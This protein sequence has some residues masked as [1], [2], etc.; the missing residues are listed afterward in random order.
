MKQTTKT[1]SILLILFGLIACGHHDHENDHEHEHA[2]D[3]HA[4]HEH[5]GSEILFTKEQQAKVDFATEQAK[6]TA[7]NQVIKTTAQILPAQTEERIL[8]AKTNGVVSFASQD[9]LSGKTV[10]KGQTLLYVNA[11][12][13]ADN[14]LAIRFAEAESQYIRTKADY[15][16]KQA[17]AEQNIIS[18]SD[19]LQAKTDYQ[20]AEVNYNNLKANFS[21]GRQAVKA[22]INGFIADVFVQNGA[23]AAAGQPLVR[24]TN[25]Q[26]MLIQADVQSK[27]YK[28]LAGITSANIIV[29]STKEKHSLKDING[30][31]VSYGKSIDTNH[32]L[33]PVTFSI[34]NKIGL[35]PGSFV[36]MYI[37]LRTVQDAI[38][39]PNEA[40]V[41]E[42]GAF[43]VMIKIEDEEYEKRPI[44]QGAT[45]GFQ[46]EIL[47]GL[48]VDEVFVSKGAVYVK[49][50]QSA[51]A[52]DA[53][54]GHVH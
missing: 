5:S 2:H 33:I 27:Y 14:N 51:G 43:F 37:Q 28:E 29:P 52:L 23:Y 41:E 39:V 25:N 32:P 42:M 31:L 10:S 6:L 53:H 40:L 21:V 15:E 26:R 38:V 7:F 35:I 34:D 9:L 49:L 45:D 1:F 12:G 24:I 19:L 18:A 3:A 17:L 22:D 13:M 30:K 50:A 4:G 47:S 48:A 44:V 16:R 36:E 54:S 20:N 8:V 11:A 46:T